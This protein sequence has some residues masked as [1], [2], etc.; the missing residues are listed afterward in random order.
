VA[1]SQ[2]VGIWWHEIFQHFKSFKFFSFHF[3]YV[4]GQTCAQCQ[5]RII[6]S[7]KNS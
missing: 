7:C 6:D 1:P 3:K 2:V 5:L 4:E